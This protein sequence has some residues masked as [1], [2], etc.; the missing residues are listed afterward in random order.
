MS[1]QNSP[2]LSNRDKLKVIV[3][4]IYPFAENS[5]KLWPTSK[6]GRARFCG[7]LPYPKSDGGKRDDGV[8]VARGLFV[9]RRDAP[10]VLEL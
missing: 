1:L 2:R 3:D 5:P 4:K 10:E 9:S 6:V 7:H 8:V